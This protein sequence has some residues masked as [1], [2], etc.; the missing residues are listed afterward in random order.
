[1]APVAAAVVPAGAAPEAAAA[2]RAAVVPVGA[3]PE[4]ADVA[5]S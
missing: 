3:A 4:A 5:A 1:M 2:I